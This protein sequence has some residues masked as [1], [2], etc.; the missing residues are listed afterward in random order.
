MERTMEQRVN[1]KFC[2]KLQKSPS[3]R[4][5]MLKKAYGG[6]TM[7]KSNDFKWPKV[8]KEATDVKVQD[9]NNVDLIFR[10]QGIIHFEFVPEGTTV[11][12]TFYVV[13]KRLIDVVRRKRGEL[14]ISLIDSLPRQRAGT[15]FAPS[16]TVFSRKRHLRHGSLDLA[17]ADFSLFP[18]LKSVPDLVYDSREAETFDEAYRTFREVFLAVINAELHGGARKNSKLIIVQF[19]DSFC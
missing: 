2:V 12:Q 8:A 4:L 6:S 19:N 9:Q 5:E 10:H 3:E 14:W 1:L 18:K 17:S 11:N 15:F 13:L 16:V 7:S